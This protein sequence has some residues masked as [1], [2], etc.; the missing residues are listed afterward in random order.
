MQLD[1]AAP[2]AE[3]ITCSRKA[4]TLMHRHGSKPYRLAGGEGGIEAVEDA[5]L[6]GALAFAVQ[7]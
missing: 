6:V 4:S 3:S 5:H 1:G 7:I 2:N